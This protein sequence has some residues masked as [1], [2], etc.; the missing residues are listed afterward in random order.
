MVRSWVDLCVCVCVCVRACVRAPD[1]E[2]RRRGGE[3]SP[4]ASACFFK[5]IF[6]ISKYL[7][8]YISNYSTISGSV[9]KYLTQRGG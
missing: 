1:V 7:K 8:F 3:G 6:R 2:L 5:N 9:R 4:D